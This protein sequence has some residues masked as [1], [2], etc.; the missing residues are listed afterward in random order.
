M[1]RPMRVLPQQ[2][3]F[4]TEQ[5]DAKQ[6]IQGEY[7]RSGERQPKSRDSIEQE[8]LDSVTIAKN[9]FFK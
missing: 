4:L 3:W 8:Q 2:D 6:G 9:P 7:S 5:G 1:A